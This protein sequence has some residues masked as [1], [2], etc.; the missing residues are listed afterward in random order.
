MLGDIIYGTKINKLIGTRLI[1]IEGEIP[2]IDVTISQEGILKASMDATSLVT[3]WSELQKDGP[4][5]AEGQGVLILKDDRA[6]TATWIGKGIAHYQNQTRRDVGSV[7]FKSS[8]NDKLPFLN[9][10]VGAFE[11]E[12][13]EEGTSKGKIWEWK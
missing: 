9:N 3:F 4:I 13:L 7:F 11:Y 8:N 2:K 12:I 6:A 1:S 10:I 5:Y